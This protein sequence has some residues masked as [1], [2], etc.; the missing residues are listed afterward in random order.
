MKSVT[1]ST[2]IV[3]F[4]CFLGFVACSDEEAPTQSARTYNTTS[5]TESPADYGTAESE[6]NKVQDLVQAVY[7]ELRAGISSENSVL[8]ECATVMFDT[9]LT[10][11][12]LVIDFGEDTCLCANWDGRYRKGKLIIAFI[13]RYRN[14]GSYYTVNSDQYFVGENEH[15]IH[16]E[17]RN[18]GQ[19]SQKQWVFEVDVSDTVIT[20]KGLIQW[21]A[22][23]NRT[24]TAGANTPL[25]VM[26]DVYLITDRNNRAAEGINRTGQNFKVLIVKPIEVKIGC[27]YKLVSGVVSLT[28]NGGVERIIDYGNG[29]CDGKFTFTI[30][31]QSFSFD[32]G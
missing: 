18:V 3:L 20:E 24:W 25:E 28:P 7:E 19:N 11:Y 2:L 15:R 32:F 30:R 26:D 13:G 14:S 22:R 16:H 31:N 27:R 10:P 17:V 6:A 9:V 5:D 29:V 1:P 8:P 21:Q 12:S 4:F 23:R